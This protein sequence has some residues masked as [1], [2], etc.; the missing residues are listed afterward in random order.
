MKIT[1]LKIERM[2]KGI[3]QYQLAEDLDISQC[4]LSQIEN[5]KVNP[6]VHLSM[7]IEGYFNKNIKELLEEI[8]L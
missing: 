5:K 6:G 8:D 7:A 2:R 1:K 4:Y 3:N